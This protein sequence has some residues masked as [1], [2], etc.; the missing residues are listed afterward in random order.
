MPSTYDGV[1]DSVTARIHEHARSRPEWI[2]T[3]ENHLER[4]I[5]GGVSAIW[6]AYGLSF[7]MDEN[8]HD[9]R[10]CLAGRYF[11]GDFG[12]LALLTCG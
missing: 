12:V 11:G 3:F 1:V 5:P 7:T 8:W 6:R 9:R 2:A 4:R 10:N